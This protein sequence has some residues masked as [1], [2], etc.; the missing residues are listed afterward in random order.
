MDLNWVYW[1]AKNSLP[2]PSQTHQDL[3]VA[4]GAQNGPHSYCQGGNDSRT[5]ICFEKQKSRCGQISPPTSPAW[6][7]GAGSIPARGINI[8]T[9]V[10]VTPFWDWDGSSLAGN[11]LLSL[12]LY[13][14]GASSGT[15]MHSNST[16]TVG[17]LIVVLGCLSTPSKFGRFQI[18]PAVSPIFGLGEIALFGFPIGQFPHPAGVDGPAVGGALSPAGWPRRASRQAQHA[19]CRWLVASRAARSRVFLLLY[20]SFKK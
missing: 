4:F 19:V 9:F 8:V 20:A 12:A 11:K 6:W 16:S 18:W 17:A 2:R 14:F 5:W 7:L 13:E 1:A 10:T 15:F 3:G